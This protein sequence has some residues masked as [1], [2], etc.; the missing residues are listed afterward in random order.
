MTTGLDT[1]V[2]TAGRIPPTRDG[3]VAAGRDG[4]VAAA[5]PHSLAVAPP[6]LIER[7]P[8]PEQIR[9]G[10][11]RRLPG[12]CGLIERA[13]TFV[14][15]IA[16]RWCRAPGTTGRLRRIYHV[17]R[18]PD[19]HAA[20]LHRDRAAAA[21]HADAITYLHH[22]ETLLRRSPAEQHQPPAP[23][24]YPQTLPQRR[25]QPRPEPLDGTWHPHQTPPTD[26][27][28]TDPTNTSTCA[29]CGQPIT[30]DEIHGW[31]HT[32][33]PGSSP[34]ERTTS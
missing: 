7:G 2:P 3:G 21:G 6:D 34:T 27:P 28:R 14:Q 20:A 23:T 32:L 13:R 30:Y 9:V 15:D 31:L 17:L 16:C 29:Q 25:H 19:P 26:T 22:A 4:T 10:H 33:T 5:H 12:E 11:M 18:D 8:T 1:T 24:G